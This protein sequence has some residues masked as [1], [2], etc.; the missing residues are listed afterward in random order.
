MISA[1]KLFTQAAAAN[2]QGYRAMKAL[3]EIKFELG[4]LEEA[5]DLIERLLVLQVTGG[6]QV[7][8][9]LNDEKEP[10]PGGTRRR[11]RHAVRGGGGGRLN[12]YESRHLPPRH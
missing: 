8:V 6:H 10:V 3:A 1:E 12:G 11:R 5:N 2:P 7:L 4:K 9:Y